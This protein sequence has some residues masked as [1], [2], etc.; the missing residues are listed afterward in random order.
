MQAEEITFSKFKELTKKKEGIVCLGCGGDPNEWIEGVTK[1][2]NDEKIVTGT[3]DQIWNN[4]YKLTT[5][6]GRT[7]IA[8]VSDNCLKDFNVGKMAIWR[9]RMGDCSWISDYLVNYA[10]HF[11][12]NKDGTPCQ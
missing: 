1:L 6:G 3:S 10:K 7:D 9:I 8:F 4:I 12:W 11:R 2:L 5:S